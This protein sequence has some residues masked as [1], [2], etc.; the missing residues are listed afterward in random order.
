M[1]IQ[2]DLGGFV[3]AGGTMAFTAGYWALGAL[4][5]DVMAFFGCDMVYPTEG[6]H[7]YGNGNADPLRDD[8]TL[9]N[10]EAKSARLSIIAARASARKGLV[11]LRS[12]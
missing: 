11:A 3:Y 7:F 8:I 6:S 4:R 12:R 9:R 2:N 1:P 5:P 10:L